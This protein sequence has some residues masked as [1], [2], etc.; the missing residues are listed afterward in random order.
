MSEESS[1]LLPNRNE[2]TEAMSQGA[3]PFARSHPPCRHTP[4]HSLHAAVRPSARPPSRALA[5]ADPPSILPLPPAVAL[6]GRTVAR[7]L[8][9]HALRCAEGTQGGE[10]CARDARL[11]DWTTITCTTY[12]AVR[13]RP[14]T[15]EHSESECTQAVCQLYLSPQR[16]STPRPPIYQRAI[17]SPPSLRHCT[18]PPCAPA[19][20]PGRRRSVHPGPAPPARARVVSPIRR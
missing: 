9:F 2:R 12:N 16:Y 6:A 20:P 15:E 18:S 19:T 13:R 17:L 8:F 5:D 1:P 4:R 11:E 14:G 10:H 7:S 3:F